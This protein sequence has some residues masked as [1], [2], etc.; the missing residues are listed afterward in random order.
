MV[1]RI[2]ESV[3]RRGLRQRLFAFAY[4]RAG[5]EIL[6][7]GVAD[8][9]RR[10]LVPLR[11]TVIEFGPG[12]GAN[13]A[14]LT[15]ESVRWIG[16]EP[17]TFMHGA[18]LQT[19]AH[20]EIC[21]ELRATTAEASGL[22]DACADAVISTHVLCS[23]TDPAAACRE[24]LRL[25]RPGG[26]F[27]SIEHVAGPPGSRLRQL[28]RAIRPVWSRVA[29]GCHPDRDLESAIRAAGFSRIEITTFRIGA[30]VVSP[31]IA[32]QAWK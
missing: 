2:E 9:K 16:I 29:D 17:N 15:P 10:L 6:L 27:V 25:L 13:L 23:V 21:G 30:P 28:Q 4:R 22:P 3:G 8:H 14:W 26:V 11:G 24:A 7:A 31:H 5:N 18:L 32:G 1:Q 12:T 20:Y 19:A